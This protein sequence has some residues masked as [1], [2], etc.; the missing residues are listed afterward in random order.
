MTFGVPIPRGIDAARHEVTDGECIDTL[1]RSLRSLE[2]TIERLERENAR[3]RS[4]QRAS[5]EAFER[6]SEE[7]LTAWLE[8]ALLRRNPRP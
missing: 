5:A 7:A 4:N 8:N 2:R 3:L 1:A 6:L